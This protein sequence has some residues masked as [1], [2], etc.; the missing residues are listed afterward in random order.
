MS[1][2]LSA[3][4]VKSEIVFANN[5]II[6]EGNRT[7]VDRVSNPSN[8]LL[9]IEFSSFRTINGR[10]DGYMDFRAKLFSGGS[11]LRDLSKEK[12]VWVAEADRFNITSGT[13][14]TVANNI[15]SAIIEG[16]QTDGFIK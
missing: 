3:K 16:L 8:P 6:L 5:R 12:A 13:Y 14:E 15:V 1:I 2:K 10:W 11:I 4:N 9:L 7:F